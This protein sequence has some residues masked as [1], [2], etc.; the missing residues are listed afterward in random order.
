MNARVVMTCAVLAL[1]GCGGAGPSVDLP[2]IAQGEAQPV[3]AS[4]A[5]VTAPTP[6]VAPVA[7]PSSAP[8]AA[9]PT[10]PAADPAPAPVLTQPAAQAAPPS[11]SKFAFVVSAGIPVSVGNGDVV[12]NSIHVYNVDPGSGAWSEVTGSPFDASAEVKDLEVDDNLANVY[13]ITESAA[14]VTSITQFAM[15]ANGAL[16]IAAQYVLPQAVDSILINPTGKFLYVYGDVVI[17]NYLIDPVAGTLTPT[18]NETSAPT[19][20]ENTVEFSTDGSTLYDGDVAA[21]TVDDKTG[22]LTAVQ[23][24]TYPDTVTCESADCQVDYAADILYEPGTT[25]D[26]TGAPVSGTLTAYDF[27]LKQLGSQQDTFGGAFDLQFDASGAFAYQTL[28]NGG[29]ER[30]T[31]TAYTVDPKSGALSPTGFTLPFPDPNG[32]LQIVLSL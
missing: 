18:I 10:A 25:T 1:A 19:P 32:V 9:P 31:V 29:T 8:A 6:T 24:P 20:D 15:D 26:G 17:G 27:S 28:S 21:Y 5:P 4:A 30:T 3:T 14:G 13:A 11:V 2:S 12:S 23:N 7:P 22:A 16:A